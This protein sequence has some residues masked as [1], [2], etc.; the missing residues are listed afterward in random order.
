M[1]RR[2]AF[3]VTIAGPERHDGHAPSTFVVHAD[4]PAEAW[5]KV[6][7]RFVAMLGIRDVVKVAVEAGSPGKLC[8]YTWN[9]LRKKEVKRQAKS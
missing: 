2:K 5:K 4:S 1:V 8:G 3:T 7:R 9:D 6:R